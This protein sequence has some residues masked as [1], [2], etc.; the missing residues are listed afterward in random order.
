M[1]KRSPWMVKKG[2]GEDGLESGQWEARGPRRGVG[3]MPVGIT[4]LRPR[5][6][7]VFS[8]RIHKDSRGVAAR[9]NSFRSGRPV[10]SV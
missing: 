2:E 1:F 4:A 6:F 3:N 5:G 10:L 8:R 9:R 7:K